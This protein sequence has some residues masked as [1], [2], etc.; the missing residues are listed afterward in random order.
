LGSSAVADIED[1]STNVS[2]IRH[3]NKIPINLFSISFLLS[4]YQNILLLTVG[5]I[6]KLNENPK[7]KI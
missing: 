3:D 7:S 4:I 5:Y 1:P 6:T 2:A